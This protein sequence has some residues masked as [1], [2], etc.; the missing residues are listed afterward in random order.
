MALK[1]RKTIWEHRRQHFKY[2]AEMVSLGVSIYYV[3][4]SVLL[5]NTTLYRKIQMNLHPGPEWRIDDVI[6]HFSTVIFATSQ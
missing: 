2:F 1:G 4:R 6:S 5:E 3:D